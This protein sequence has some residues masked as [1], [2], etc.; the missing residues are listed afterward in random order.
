MIS[1]EVL[2][3]GKAS[4][5]VLS[6]SI[7]KMTDMYRP[8]TQYEG[9]FK[10]FL[11]LRSELK[12]FETRVYVDNTT[13][14][15][16]LRITKDI[17]DVTVIKYDCPDFHEKNGHA[18]TFGT[19]VRFLPLFE[20]GLETVWITDIDIQ[21]NFLNKKYL[22]AIDQHKC[23][24]MIESMICYSEKRAVKSK[25]PIIATR[26]ISKINYPKQLLTNFLNRILDGKM[27]DVI[28]RINDSNTKKPYHALAPYGIDE[29]FLNGS[30]Y[31]A[32]KRRNLKILV[33]K[34]YFI[35]NSI[36][37]NIPKTAEEELAL[38]L[39]F[40]ATLTP[41]MVQTIVKFYKRV[42]PDIVE[43][44]PCYAEMQDKL[45]KFKN[46]LDEMFIIKSHDL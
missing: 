5:H 13:A 41:K 1:T 19:I 26:L 35:T 38:K 17:E 29:A 22:E 42:L 31:E 39:S 45:D 3:Q 15:I 14:D 28:Q 9:D 2:K 37:K 20:S 11:G 10:K 36:L 6:C 18:G 44:H 40:Y 32:M 23:D 27:D 7:F 21:P 12:G 43:D 16:I 33:R 8:F 24:M 34:T 46:S 4:K 30:F 25:I